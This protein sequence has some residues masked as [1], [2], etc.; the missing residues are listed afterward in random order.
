MPGNFFRSELLR[1]ILYGSLALIMNVAIVPAAFGQQV[2]Q[3]RSPLPGAAIQIQPSLQIQHL[4]STRNTLNI[5]TLGDS[6]MW[7]QGL[8]EQMKFRTLVA[9][10]LQ[11]QWTT[12]RTVTQLTTHAHSGAVT[13]MGA[14]PS[15]SN[16]HDPDTWFM[17]TLQSYPYPGEVPFDYPSISFQI[18]MTLS[19]LQRQGVSPADIDLVLL[20]GGI[21]DLSVENILNPALVETNLLQ[22]EV[23]NGPN[24]VRTKTNQLCVT[25]MQSL[26]PQVLNA[27]PNAAVVV[28]GYY[29][30]VSNSTDLLLLDEYLGIIGLVPGAAGLATTGTVGG[31]LAGL[32]TFMS[33]AV[34][35]S[36]ALRAVLADRSSAFAQ[37]A[38]NSM[39]DVINQSNQGLP[40][41]R[42]ALAWPAFNDNNSYGGPYT[43]LFKAGENL[44]DEI[45]GGN[46]QAPP[47][48]W[49]TP[50]GIAYYRGE[51][52]SNVSTRSG[53]TGSLP[54]CY[55]ASIGHP[56]PLGAQA[57]ANAI[58]SQLQT[59]LAA[60]IMPSP[61]TATIVQQG[62]SPFGGTSWIKIK[63]TDPHGNEVPG[64]VAINGASGPTEQ[65]VVFKNDCT[66]DQVVVGYNKNTAGSATGVVV[67]TGKKEYMTCRGT[68]SA[69]GFAPAQFTAGYLPSKTLP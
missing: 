18:G 47:G 3:P 42:V 46:W 54:K 44:S 40:M 6:I 43:Y 45:R 41:P 34:P 31:A 56:N 19:D 25:H 11:S 13:G 2:Q 37:T 1:R 30:I 26:L 53:Y 8:P 62:L 27:F 12:T 32:G 66:M 36:P 24:W 59:T 51:E 17:G 14:W 69:P 20:D 67:N 4:T 9:N 21:N 7:G 58:I 68:V 65:N 5:V 16:N 28:T 15:S 48:N 64:T 23:A 50:Q 33:V 57:F 29:P 49:Q 10:W 63:A 55:D 60:R 38:F 52:C 22:G 35:A 39:T 61:L